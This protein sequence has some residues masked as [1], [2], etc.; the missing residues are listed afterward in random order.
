MDEIFLTSNLWD[1][2]V[3]LWMKIKFFTK[4]KSSHIIRSNWCWT[5]PFL[6]IIWDFW[7][8]RGKKKKV[9]IGPFFIPYSKHAFETFI[10]VKRAKLGKLGL[11]LN[12]LINNSTLMVIC[13]TTRPTPVHLSFLQPLL[14]AWFYSCTSNYYYT[15]MKKRMIM[16]MRRKV[17]PYRLL[18][19]L[20]T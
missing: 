5:C 6:N 4:I 15:P 19:L 1:E 16:T 10:L 3:S 11:G 13:A 9:H 18:L 14:L 8:K 17:S 20:P 2:M 12:E 7:K